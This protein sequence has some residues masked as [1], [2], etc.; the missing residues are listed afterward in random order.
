MIKKKSLE[1]QHLNDDKNDRGDGLSTCAKNGYA[2]R[3]EQDDVK[4]FV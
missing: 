4:K 1:I 3:W 2:A